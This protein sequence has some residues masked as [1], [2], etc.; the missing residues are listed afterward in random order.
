MNKEERNTRRDKLN[1]RIVELQNRRGE[2]TYEDP[3]FP[4]ADWKAEVANDDTQRGYFDWAIEKLVD[5][6]DTGLPVRRKDCPFFDLCGTKQADCPRAHG[7]VPN[8]DGCK[9][10]TPKGT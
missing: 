3:G 4:R 10:H 9:A 6:R 2:W 1:I 5:E 7:I 8:G